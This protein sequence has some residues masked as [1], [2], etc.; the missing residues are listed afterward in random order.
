MT[1][2]LLETITLSS[3]VLESFDPVQPITL[4]QFVREFLKGEKKSLSVDQLADLL[5]LCENC[6]K[7]TKILSSVV[8]PFAKQTSRITLR[9]DLQLCKV[10]TYFIIFQ[11]NLYSL[12]IVQTVLDHL[13]SFSIRTFLLFLVAIDQKTNVENEKKP[14]HNEIK[15]D[16]YVNFDREFIDKTVYGPFCD[17]EEQLKSV[18]LQLEN[19]YRNGKEKKSRRSTVPLPFGLRA[20]QRQRATKQRPLSSTLNEEKS[21]IKFFASGVPETTYRPSARTVEL[22]AKAHQQTESFCRRIAQRQEQRAN[23]KTAASE[24]QSRPVGPK[25]RH[26]ASRLLIEA[27]RKEMEERMSPSPAE[28][29]AQPVISELSFGTVTNQPKSLKKRNTVRQTAAG[30]LREKA[31]FTKYKENNQKAAD[32]LAAGFWNPEETEKRRRQLEAKDM[33]HMIV[34]N[35]RKIIDA[36]QTLE[37]AIAAKNTYIEETKAKAV[38]GKEQKKLLQDQR[39]SAMEKEIAMLRAVVTEAQAAARSQLGVARKR[40]LEE[41]QQ[42][43]SEIK[44]EN[45]ELYQR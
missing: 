8:A 37:N 20:H 13:Y 23:A 3:S 22:Q 14:M 24:K 4:S 43:A 28:K 27:H 31:L 30:I 44:E 39:R 21:A 10:L 26:A 16:W 32:D 6:L 5:I 33:E 36:M 25:V 17:I 9:R 34:E 41:K 18:V 40:I 1:E 29:P 11:W 45:N 15:A 2:R 19:I 7:H 12:P 35:E 42:T 38:W